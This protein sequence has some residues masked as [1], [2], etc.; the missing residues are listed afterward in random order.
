[1]LLMGFQDSTRSESEMSLCV[2]A[3]LL[4]LFGFTCLYKFA[5]L[6]VSLPVHGA[7]PR[8]EQAR[9]LYIS[10]PQMLARQV[11]EA[12]ATVTVITIWWLQGELP[13]LAF[14]PFGLAT[15]CLVLKLAGT[16]HHHLDIA[17][18]FFGLIMMPFF[19]VSFLL[20]SITSDPL[21]L[22]HPLNPPLHM[23]LVIYAMVTCM[24]RPQSKHTV[25]MV[26]LAQSVFLAMGLVDIAIWRRFT[27]RNAHLWQ[28]VAQL[29]MVCTYIAND[30]TGP[31]TDVS[32][33]SVMFAS[34]LWLTTICILALALNWNEL[35]RYYQTWQRQH[36]T[37]TLRAS[38]KAVAV[39]PNFSGDLPV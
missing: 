4:A 30:P 5:V 14:L 19:L 11:A 15:L 17:K 26:W 24:A 28:Y 16:W 18:A 33:A 1:M 8:T 29:A 32:K 7:P 21:R 35:T 27:W 3:G 34:G 9:R 6:L 39:R 23:M 22:V 13:I 10:D 38:P 31:S 20:R 2:R 36:S 37:F 12:F 25:V